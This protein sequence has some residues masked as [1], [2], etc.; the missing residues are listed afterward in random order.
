MRDY[1]EFP[2]HREL[3]VLIDVD[4]CFACARARARMCVQERRLKRLSSLGEN[5]SRTRREGVSWSVIIQGGNRPFDSANTAYFSLRRFPLELKEWCNGLASIHVLRD[6]CVRIHVALLTDFE[7]VADFLSI[8]NPIMR[9][10]AIPREIL[11][12]LAESCRERE[13]SLKILSQ[14]FYTLKNEFSECYLSLSEILRI[15]HL[16]NATK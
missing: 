7:W 13:L 11:R 8:T 5:S 9:I 16:V 15:K 2:N 10:S 6:A 14:F 4:R 3:Y 12:T 1:D